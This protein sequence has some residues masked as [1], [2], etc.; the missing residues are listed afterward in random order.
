MLEFNTQELK[1]KTFFRHV[2]HCPHL[3]SLL[4]RTVKYLSPTNR[5]K[6]IIKPKPETA[7]SSTIAI[8]LLLTCTLDLHTGSKVVSFWKNCINYRKFTPNIK[9]LSNILSH[10]TCYGLW[11]SLI[12]LNRHK[13]LYVVFPQQIQVAVLVTLYYIGRAQPTQ[14]LIEC[15]ELLYAPGGP[16]NL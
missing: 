1:K 16:P 11:S 3:S 4:C 7:V 10:N 5:V 15:I 6:I 14:Q 9:G 12:A 2:Y 13:L 8:K